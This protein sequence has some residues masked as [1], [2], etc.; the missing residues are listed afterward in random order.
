MSI[1]SYVF[2]LDILI[3]GISLLNRIIV[4]DEV[5]QN[6]HSENVSEMQKLAIICRY[7]LVYYL[8]LLYIIYTIFIYT[9]ILIILY[10]VHSNLTMVFECCNIC[11]M[12]WCINKFDGFNHI[13][14]INCVCNYMLLNYYCVYMYVFYGHKLILLRARFIN[15][16]YYYIIL[17]YVILSTILLCIFVR[18]HI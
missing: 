3:W 17:Y 2:V 4:T 5:Y 14:T 8:Y 13:T 15:K 11:K 9:Y 10:W 1:M 12:S 7:I 6:L 18:K 16:Q